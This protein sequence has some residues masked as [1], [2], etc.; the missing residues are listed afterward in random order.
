[1]K[2]IS[3]KLIESGTIIDE[4]DKQILVKGRNVV[5]PVYIK[6]LPYPGFPT[7]MQAQFM[8]YLCSAKG[9]SVITESVFENRFMHVPELLRM[10]A[11]I[12]TEGRTAIIKGIPT[13]TSANVKATDLRAG[14]ALVL[15]GMVAEGESIIN[16]S[17]H[18]YRGYENIINKLK[19][20]GAHIE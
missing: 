17:H 1:M 10:G 3:A 2:A 13:L 14:A 4:Q 5:K 12:K 8:A 9:S 18:I 16:N 6:T 11:E 7:D 20:L 19:N 15:A